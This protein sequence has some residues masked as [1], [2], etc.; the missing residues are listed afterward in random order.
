[1][2]LGNRSGHHDQGQSTVSSEHSD[3]PRR[4]PQGQSLST[5]SS[6]TAQ[7]LFYHIKQEILRTDGPGYLQYE[8]ILP[9]IGYQVARSLSSD[10][11]IEREST[12][13]SYNPTTSILCVTMPTIFQGSV[14]SWAHN[15]MLTK[16]LN[17]F[18]TVNE[19]Q[20]LILGGNSRFDSFP[21]PWQY[22]YKEPDLYI[23]QFWAAF[24]AI[25]FEAGYSKSYEK[26]LSDK[27]LWFIGAP[28][29][30]VVVLIKWS[31]VA[32]NRIRGFIELWR[33]A[34]PGT[35]R[36]QIFP[37]PAPGTQSQSLTFFRQDFYVG[38]IVPAGRQPLDPCPWDIDDLRRYANEAIRAE[39]LVPE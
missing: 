16:C 21:H 26:L 29:V 6:L 23:K 27:D 24:P 3:A 10:G 14:L 31:K 2:A 11:D 36:I 17:G 1:M 33:R 20:D 22:I 39:G 9:H 28:Q 32:N 25:V 30:N 12:T 7:Q 34:T 15:Q 8:S 18:F 19:N 38:G 5:A 35:Q 13:I 4:V 37:T